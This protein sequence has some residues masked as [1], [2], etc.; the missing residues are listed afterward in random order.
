MQLKIY[1]FVLF[2]AMRSSG[3]QSILTNNE[4]VI[5]MCDFPK[6]MK[7][8]GRNLYFNSS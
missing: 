4:T 7:S 1:T 8:S 3:P 5:P 6:K 2:L